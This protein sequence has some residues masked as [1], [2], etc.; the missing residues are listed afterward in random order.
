MTHPAYIASARVRILRTFATRSVEVLPDSELWF[1][2]EEMR[3]F[4]DGTRDHETGNTDSET[5]DLAVNVG[6]DL[7]R[8]VRIDEELGILSGADVPHMTETL[9]TL[10]SFKHGSLQHRLQ[11]NES[12]YELH[13]AA[14]F[15]GHGQRVSFVD[16]RRPSRY[17]QRVEFMVGYKWPIECKHP[18]SKRKIIPNIDAA[19]KKLNERGQPGIIC[20]GLEQALPMAE[21]LYIEVIKA[22][23]VVARVS[24]QVAPWFAN[25]K[26]LLANR[27]AQGCGRFIIF[28]YSAHAYVHDSEMV[29]LPSL[30]L[31]LSATGDW[32]QEKVIESCLKHLWHEREETQSPD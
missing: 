24:E 18:Q 30:R 14:Q 3:L 28:T 15:Q 6:L 29:A 19:L 17:K 10:A 20:I 11:F 2:L 25:H 5:D 31:A 27:L 23:D 16:T 26:M 9:R 32:I 7:L 8:G 21:R 1:V 22:E 12:E 4:S 13:M